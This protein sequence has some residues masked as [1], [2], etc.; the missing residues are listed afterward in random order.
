MRPLPKGTIVNRKTGAMLLGIAIAAVVAVGRVS[1]SRK[2][3][4]PESGDEDKNTGPVEVPLPDDN[5]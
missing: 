1:S 3:V 5:K 4:P 2:G